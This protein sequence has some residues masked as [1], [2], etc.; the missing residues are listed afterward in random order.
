MEESVHLMFVEPQLGGA[1]GARATAEAKG[2]IV[3][4]AAFESI[5]EEFI[6]GVA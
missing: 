6:S 4:K 1:R 3:R 2:K 5:L